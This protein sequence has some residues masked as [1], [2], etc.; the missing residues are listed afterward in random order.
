MRVHKINL[1]ARDYRQDAVSG[2]EGARTQKRIRKIGGGHKTD[3]QD[4]RGDDGLERH[5]CNRGLVVDSVP[6]ANT[7]LT[8]FERI[9]GNSYA[10]TEVLPIARV[11][12]RR[13]YRVPGKDNVPRHGGPDNGLLAGPKRIHPQSL[14]ENGAKDFV[15]QTEVQSEMR[16]QRKGILNEV[17]VFAAAK[18]A[19]A[20]A[21][22]LDE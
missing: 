1:G 20:I 17:A 21:S 22:D 9:P 10:R 12:R 4:R 14:I 3:V 15:A 19:C 7:G 6:G 16:S 18:F 8:V 2:L 13:V 11:S 5:K